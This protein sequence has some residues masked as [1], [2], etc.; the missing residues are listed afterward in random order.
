MEVLFHSPSL[1]ELGSTS[2]ASPP[3]VS[4]NHAVLQVCS[5]PKAKNLGIC[6]ENCFVLRVFFVKALPV[7]NSSV[8]VG[9][10]LRS[11]AV[12]E[13]HSV[14]VLWLWL[15]LGLRELCR[16]EQLYEQGKRSNTES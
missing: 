12:A 3:P 5:F 10:Q 2:P 16:Q 7:F 14:L 11:A 8:T 15:L 4:C 9:V 6:L 1:D 13:P